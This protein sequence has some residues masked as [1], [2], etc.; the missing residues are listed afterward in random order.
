M[1][2]EDAD[3]YVNN[4]IK[5]KYGMHKVSCHNS[6]KMTVFNQYALRKRWSHET[7]LPYGSF[8]E[9][10]YDYMFHPHNIR[11]Y[12]CCIG[13]RDPYENIPMEHREW[14]LKFISSEPRH[15]LSCQGHVRL[16][17]FDITE[18]HKRS[19]QVSHVD[20]VVL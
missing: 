2:C 1:L 15:I 13:S 8:T 18:L 12:D 9:C 3:N 5:T 19:V 14:F 10:G 16:N 6:G 4:D 20:V 17:D 7:S 11:V